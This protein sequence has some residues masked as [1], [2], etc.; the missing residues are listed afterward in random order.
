MIRINGVDYQSTINDSSTPGTPIG[1]YHLAN[2]PNIYE[3]QRTNNFEFIVSDLDGLVQPGT[4]N[5][6]SNAQELIRIA[7]QSAPI[8]F[9]SQSVLE[10]KRG[11]NT[12]KYAGVPTYEAGS[13]VLNDYIGADIAGILS[14]WQALSYNSKTEKVG[15]AS[16]YKKTCSVIQYSPDYQVVRTWKMY[17]CWISGLSQ[18]DMNNENNDVVKI[19]ATIQ[20]DRAEIDTSGIE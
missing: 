15:H 19:T 9:F 4:S 17:G 11:N 1:T 10:V 14:A 13:I 12:L 2:N 16:D 20:Y 18:S 5:V 7:C 8:P 3:I 6:Y